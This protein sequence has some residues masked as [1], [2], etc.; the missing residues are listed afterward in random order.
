MKRSICFLVVVLLT[1]CGAK[2]DQPPAAA[3]PETKPAALKQRGMFTVDEAAQRKAGVEVAP[4]KVRDLSGSVSSQ[5]QLALNEDLTWRV[6]AV[7]GGRVESLPVKLGDMVK[8]G[9]VIARIHSHDEH[10]ARA[11]YE[12]AISELDRA[13]AAHAYLVKRRDRAKRLLELRAGSVQDVESAESELTSAQAGIEKAQA[14]LTMEK[15]HLTDILHVPL[16]EDHSAADEVEGI[17]LFA[18]ASGVV[19]SRRATEGSVV[20]TGEEVLSIADLS[21]IWMIAAVNE[22]DLSR[23]RPGQNVHVHVRAYPDREF[24]GKVLK[25]GEKLDPETRTLQVRVGI[26]NPQGLLK[27]EMYATADFQQPGGHPAIFVPGEAVQDVNGV[28]ATFVRRSATDFEVRAVKT[29]QRSNGEVE[30]LEGLKQGDVVAGKGS[31]LLKSELLKS[32]IEDE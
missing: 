26:P 12:Q 16:K 23:L 4:V 9:Q 21:V 6:G 3:K 2:N 13:K 31:F 18:P 20:N 25:L 17:P 29:G 1:G 10:E 11:A 5:G 19:Y 22:T 27:P 15:T 24:S 14:Q 32:T 30:I 7:A 8:G 28:S